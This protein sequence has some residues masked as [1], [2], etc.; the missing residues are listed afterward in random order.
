MIPPTSWEAPNV[1]FD[2]PRVHQAKVV[3][4][5][6]APLSK[7]TAVHLEYPRIGERLGGIQ[8]EDT[9]WLNPGRMR[10]PGLGI[11]YVA[12]E[13]DQITGPFQ[14]TGRSR[15]LVEAI[16]RACEVDGEVQQ[17]YLLVDVIAERIIDPNAVVTTQQLDH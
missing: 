17:T 6:I 1:T 9:H 10:L 2:S 4:A 7:G 15:G 13:S 8:P 16:V 11:T 14:W 5:G 12:R 3:F